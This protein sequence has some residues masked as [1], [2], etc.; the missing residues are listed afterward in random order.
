[1]PCL[2]H[3]AKALLSFLFS[4]LPDDCFAGG[5]RWSILQKV[6][7]RFLS[8]VSQMI[9]LLDAS[10]GSFSK[11]QALIFLSHMIFRCWMHWLWLVY[12]AL[13]LRCYFICLPHGVP[14]WTLWPDHFVL[15]FFY[16][17]TFDMC[18]VHGVSCRMPWT[19]LQWFFCISL[20]SLHLSHDF[21][22]GLLAC[23][24]FCFPHGVSCWVPWLEGFSICVFSFIGFKNGVFCWMPCLRHSAKALLSFLFSGLPDDCFA[25]G[26]R[27]SILQKVCFRFLSFVSQMISLLDASAGSFSKVQAL[28]F[29]SHMIFR[30]WMHWLW[31][32]YFALG[33]R[34][35]FICLPHGVPCW[36]LWPDHFVL[37]F[38]YFFTFD[39]CLVHGVSCRM[40][41]TILQ[42]FFLHFFTF[43]AFVS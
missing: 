15:L 27:W 32:V 35:Y 16:F 18:L 6:C 25:G 21:A 31:L 37:L 14:C 10:A 1:M 11:V 8:F 41:W 30:C 40:P 12:F 38:F 9:S 17:F 28:I 13:G 20:H 5:R 23:L 24:F 36:T 22:P 2:R 42:W 7:F 33:L 26:R 34:C 29:L 3:S 43:F 4:G 19:I 39:M